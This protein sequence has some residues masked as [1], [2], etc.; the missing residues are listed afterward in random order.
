MTG[1]HSR[2][3]PIGIVNIQGPGYVLQPIDRLPSLIAS[4]KESD[5]LLAVGSRLVSAAREGKDVSLRLWILGNGVQECICQG[6][7]GIGQKNAGGIV[8]TGN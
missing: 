4:A 1:Q 7:M 6:E 3:R 5:P 8:S 2:W